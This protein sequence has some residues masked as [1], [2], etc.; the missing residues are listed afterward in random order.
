MLEEQLAEVGGIELLKFARVTK[1]VL[2]R[3]GGEYAAIADAAE[4]KVCR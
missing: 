3:L 4:A 1:Q 2:R